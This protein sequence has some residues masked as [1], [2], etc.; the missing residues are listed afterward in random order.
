MGAKRLCW[1][2]WWQVGGGDGGGGLFVALPGGAR[3]RLINWARP[4]LPVFTNR[5]YYI[6]YRTLPIR[7]PLHANTRTTAA[8]SKGHPV[9]MFSLL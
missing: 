6:I 3:F 2:N 4:M 5:P 7:L 9:T 1:V 8:L